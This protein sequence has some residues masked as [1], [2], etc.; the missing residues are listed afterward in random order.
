MAR[1][2]VR[3]RVEGLKATMTN[4]QTMSTK[5]QASIPKAAARSATTVLKKAV[6]SNIYKGISMIT[7]LMQRGLGVHVRFSTSGDKVSAYVVE[8]KIKTTG[9]S[10]ASKAALKNAI[11]R[12][13][14]GKAVAKKYGAFYWRFL[15]FGVSHRATKEGANR[16]A[17]PA[18]G[19]V[20]Q[21]FSSASALAI[22]TFRTVLKA[23]TDKEL[24]SLPR[25][26]GAK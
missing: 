22:D 3:T 10:K 14:V 8:N 12:T 7:G 21:S 18:T 1:T 23:R 15:E 25:T 9:K 5:L 19:N 16:G 4:L 2:L 17:L 13:K 20:R 26:K 6:A 24:S 11:R